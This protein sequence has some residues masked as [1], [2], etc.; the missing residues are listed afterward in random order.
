[1]KLSFDRFSEVAP[2]VE[3]QD[4]HFDVTGKRG[5]VTMNFDLRAEGASIGSGE[6]QIIMSG[7][8]PYQQ[9]DIDHLVDAYNSGR[10]AYQRQ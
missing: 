4:C 6:K 2:E 3:L 8:R 9:E 1:M 5:M 7:L 10:E